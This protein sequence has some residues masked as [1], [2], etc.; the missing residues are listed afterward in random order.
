MPLSDVLKLM[1]PAFCE[2][3]VLVGI[4]SYLGI[5]VIKRKV[6][7]VDL[8]LAQIA[9]LGTLFAFLFGIA[10][11]TA[12]AYVFSVGLTAAAAAVFALCRFRQGKIPQEAVIGL[13]YAIAAAAGILLIDKA[14][15]GA[16]HIKEIL[17]GSILWVKWP[18]ILIAALVYSAVGV[19]HYVFRRRFLLISENPDEAYAR[20]I[21]VRFWDFLFY[22][23]FGVVI[24]VSVDTAGV[25]IVFVF[26]VA[27]AIVAMSITDDIRKQL[28]IGWTLG[29]FVT[30]GGL[31]LSYAGDLPT[32]PAVIG[33][34]GAAVLA[35]A[36]GLY[37]L[38][39]PDR[40]RAWSN[41]V[42]AA[43]GFAALFGLLWLLANAWP[44]PEHEGGFGHHPPAV[45]A[46]DAPPAGATTEELFAA[47]DDPQTRSDL[48]MQAF[49]KDRT[50]GVRLAVAFLRGDPPLFF[51][52]DV[53]DKLEEEAGEALGYDLMLIFY[54]C[55]PI[56][57]ATLQYSANGQ[58]IL[59][60]VQNPRLNVVPRRCAL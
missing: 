10:P 40:G 32:G 22:L 44:A 55:S 23:S 21:N 58:R 19:F 14:P 48:V 3:L 51:R 57:K 47:S 20:G 24:T 18:T 5:H 39:A 1:F 41:V 50:V 17:T 6:I 16:E 29:L 59:I 7:F 49:G 43:M 34:Y 33:A 4:H 60:P 35:I 45:E 26:L 13:V 31:V 12:G 27:P 30:T 9:A 52:Q 56:W 46:S 25:L 54:S 8:A 42:L 2:C 53:L 38:R 36:V 15:H 37:L 11:H 28:A